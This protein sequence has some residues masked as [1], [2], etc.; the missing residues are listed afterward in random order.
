MAGK[1]KKSTWGGKR[2]GAGRPR[3]D[4]PQNAAYEA[5]ELYQPGRTFIYLPTLEARNE[6]TNGT[7]AN[8][9]RKARWLYNNV[10]LAARAVDG[11]ARY[12]C[13][14]GI[15][16]AA[17]S[18][19]DEWNKQAESMFEDACGR[20]AFGFD[21]AGQVN[22]YEAQ[23]FIVRHVAIDGDFFGQF[24]KSDNGRALVRFMGAE[25]IGNAATP[26]KQ[27]EWHDG[28][29]VDDYGKPTQY[30]VLESEDKG[31]FTDISA[32]DILHFRRPVR[33]GYTRSPSWLSRAAL[34]LHDMADI[35]GF[36]K[37]TF[38][39]ASQPAFVIK[40]PDAMQIGM[41]AA[42]KKQEVGGGQVT[43]DKLYS[44][45]GVVQLPPGSE[46]QQFKNEH[47]GNNFQAFLDFLARDIS[48]GIG[49]SPEMLWSVAGIGGA[50]TRY[51]LADAQ[52]FFSELQEWLINQFCRR[53]WKYWIWHE[54]EAGRLP[55]REDW[56]RV[57][58]IPPARATVDFGRDT[59]AL[60][61]IVRSGAMSTR[62][63]AEMHG[64]D[65]E[66]EEDAAIASAQRRKE[67]CE[68]AGLAVAEVFPPAPG[69]PVTPAPDSE[70]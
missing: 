52:V 66:A 55:F 38:K 3:K 27:D 23:S 40:S 44:Q 31:K 13:G 63:F 20:E 18:D 48:W 21:A 25:M 57:D 49:V 12:V 68:A 11:V 37:Q 46:L 39:L 36:T 7:R 34:H 43:L 29:R 56:W 65:E 28:V 69:S 16:P 32:D 19:D 5:G 53:F 14:T 45:S 58:F 51:V 33:V 61:E 15:I 41:G 30:R 54:I 70:V 60:L 8:L 62:R 24:V 6:L 47:P 10:G 42:L 26:L 50:N 35:I 67:K 9:M 64:W 4:L 2:P 17:R 22:F 59:K 1:I